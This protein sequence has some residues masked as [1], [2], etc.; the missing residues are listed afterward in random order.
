[1]ETANAK[2]RELYPD[3]LRG[4]ITA[5]QYVEAVMREVDQLRARLDGLNNKE[6]T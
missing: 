1:V 3:L 6:P 2:R 5:K 4:K